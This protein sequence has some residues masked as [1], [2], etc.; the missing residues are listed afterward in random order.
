MKSCLRR[1]L[2]LVVSLVCF[3]QS[4]AF[5]EPVRDADEVKSTVADVLANPEYRHLQESKPEL[6]E[7]FEFPEWV[8]SFLKWLFKPRDVSPSVDANFDFGEIIFYGSLGV[9]VVILIVFMYW[10]LN[11]GDS[12]EVVRPFGDDDQEAINPSKPAGELPANEYARRAQAAAEAGDYR[13]A[14]RELVL[15]AM[16]WTERVGLI[17]HR[18]GLTNRDYVRAIWRQ[19]ER[20][21]SLLQIV[22]A[23]ERV[24]YGHRS[25]DRL[26][27]EACFTEFE[28]SF[29]SEGSDAQPTT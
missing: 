12:S 25:A 5:A 26:T 18:R 15:G 6:D 13:T 14:I 29:L 7:D 27:F 16:S 4:A 11:V 1:I 2:L 20:R 19:V 24:F 23:F 22:A 3:S 28:R 9:L 10:T 8:K 21:E 17:R